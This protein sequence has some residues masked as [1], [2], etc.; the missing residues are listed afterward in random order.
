MLLLTS[1]GVKSFNLPQ[2]PRLI[3]TTLL[4]SVGA[5]RIVVGLEDSAKAT[6]FFLEAVNIIDLS[7]DRLR[8]TKRVSQKE[9]KWFLQVTTAFYVAGGLNLLRQKLLGLASGAVWGD[10]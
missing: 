4:G 9:I 7:H 1:F 3:L 8:G 5:S 10:L 2:P 6:S